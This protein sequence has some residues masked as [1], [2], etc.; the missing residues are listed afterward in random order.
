[1]TDLSTLAASLSEAHTLW[2]ELIREE[3]QEIAD[4]ENQCSGC[5]GERGSDTWLDY[6]QV[7]RERFEEVG[8]AYSALRDHLERNG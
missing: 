2:E 4:R 5:C 3:A 1:M 7:V 8:A 6:E